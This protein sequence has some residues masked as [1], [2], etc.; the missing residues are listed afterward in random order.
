MLGLRDHSTGG[1]AFNFRMARALR[2][3]GHS[4][5]IVHYSTLPRSIRGSRLLGTLF[6]P[7]S[8]A[9]RSKDLI[10]ISKSYSFM[11]LLRTVLPLFRTPVLYMVHHLQWHDSSGKPSRT[12]RALVRW[13]VSAGDRVWVNSESTA[14]DVSELGIP[15]ER[16][17]VIPPG[18]DAFAF[19]EY[20]RRPLPVRILTVGSICPRKDQMTLVRSCALLEG[21]D[22]ELHILGDETQDPVY[23]ASV[24]REVEKLGLGPRTFFHGHLPMEELHGFY[25]KAHLLANLSRWEGYGM[26]VAEGLYAGLPVVAA[27][28]GAVPELITDGIEGYLVPPGDADSCAER[29]SLLISDAALRE[30][31]SASAI[32]RAERLYRWTDTEREFIKLAELTAAGGRMAP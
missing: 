15:R 25:G 12:R 26:A 30:Q 2:N 5:S 20:S 27:D 22:F 13:F 14:A 11:P 32:R 29:L 31:M 6:L 17:A 10:I 24:R 23:S 4:V 19:P 9:L 7:F 8:S 28:A 21:T 16:M 3:A 18:F 1:Y